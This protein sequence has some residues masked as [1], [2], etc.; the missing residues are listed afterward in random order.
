[1]LRIGSVKAGS[2]RFNSGT[3]SRTGSIGVGDLYAEEERNFLVNLDIPVVDGV[4]DLMSLLKVRCVYR[5]PV[6]KEDVDLSSAGEV[7][8]LRPVVMAEGSRAVVSIEVDRQIIRLRAAEAISEARVLAERGDLTEAVSV[9]ET[10]RVVLNE[11][12]SGRAGDP[13]CASLYAELKETQERMASRQVYEASGRA[14][15]LAGLS[16]HSWQRATARGDMSDTTTTSYQTQS[17]VDMVNLSQTMTFGI[18]I[19]S[20]NSNSNSTSSSPSAPRK[21]RQALSFPA[22][23]RPR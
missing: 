3:D 20:S 18:P 10:C 21:L 11:S 5:D 4:S 8:I 14:Y 15:V 7:K 22:R 1:M 2:Y 6:T 13:L 17:M 12:V 23:P 9:L 19:A 16:S